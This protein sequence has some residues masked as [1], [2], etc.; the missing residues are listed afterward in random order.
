MFSLIKVDVSKAISFITTE[1]HMWKPNIH[2]DLLGLSFRI[3][4]DLLFSFLEDLHFLSV[5]LSYLAR[6]VS[7][8]RLDKV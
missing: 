2:T 5:R 1:F 4:P 8:R 6:S 7:Q 3:I